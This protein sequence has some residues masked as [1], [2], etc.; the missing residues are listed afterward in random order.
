[1]PGE[2]RSAQSPVDARSMRSESNRTTSRISR[3]TLCMKLYRKA[4]PD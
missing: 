3:A 2:S 4:T 1:M